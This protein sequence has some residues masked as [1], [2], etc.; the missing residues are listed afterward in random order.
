MNLQFALFAPLLIFCYE[1]NKEYDCVSRLFYIPFAYMELAYF[2]V[3]WQL[4][5]NNRRGFLRHWQRLRFSSLPILFAFI[6]DYGGE[7]RCCTRKFGKETAKIVMLTP[8]ISRRVCEFAK[9]VTLFCRGIPVTDE[10]SEPFVMRERAGEGDVY[11]EKL[12][13]VWNEGLKGVK[14]TIA[15]CS[16]GMVYKCITCFISKW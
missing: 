12:A 3:Y 14:W 7:L 8:L 2:G 5:F 1:T 10:P 11:F 16:W 9:N 13:R 6:R 15:Y 4:F